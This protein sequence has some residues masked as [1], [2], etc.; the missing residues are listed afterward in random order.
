MD[1]WHGRH[2]LPPA[3]QSRFDAQAGKQETSST[4]CDTNSASHRAVYAKNDRPHSPPA[5]CPARQGLPAFFVA[6]AT[7]IVPVHTNVFG[8]CD[9]GLSEIRGD[10]RTRAYGAPIGPVSSLGRT[11]IRPT[12][13]VWRERCRRTRK[14]LTPSL[15]LPLPILKIQF[16][17]IQ[18]GLSRTR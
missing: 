17:K 2:V 12:T 7:P 8:I 10:K 6:A 4:A 9:R 1:A 13:L 5:V 11:R 16:L 3:P 14:C 15:A 18:Y